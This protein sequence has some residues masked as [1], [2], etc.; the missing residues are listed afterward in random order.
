MQQDLGLDLRRS[1]VSWHAQFLSCMVLYNS[2]DR[3]R[4]WIYD[5]SFV[6]TSAALFLPICNEYNH[7]II[8][9]AQLSWVAVLDVAFA[10]IVLLT[11]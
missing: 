2:V 4:Q 9:R 10:A 11:H 7:G 1:W 5:L 6:S 3:V 8:S